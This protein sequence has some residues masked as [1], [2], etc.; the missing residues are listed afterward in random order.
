MLRQ[1][2]Q[3]LLVLTGG[4]QRQKNAP[5]TSGPQPG[6]LQIV[7]QGLGRQRRGRYPLLLRG[8]SPL[9]PMAEPFAFLPYSV[10][11]IRKDG[12]YLYTIQFHN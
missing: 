4:F 1:Q 5:P 7:Q 3:L 11:Q 9:F 8:S 12:K 2:L 6:V 10:G